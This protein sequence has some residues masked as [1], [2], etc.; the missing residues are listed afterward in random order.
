MKLILKNK[1]TLFLVSLFVLGVLARIFVF[2][3]NQ[4]L[5]V[6]ES[7]LA[8]NFLTLP[9]KGLLKGLE[10]MQASPAGYNLVNKFLLE[11]FK[12]NNVYFRDMELRLIPFISSILS[13]PAF[14]ILLKSL[15]KD[16][17]KILYGFS[18]LAVNPL[19]ILYAGQCKQYS[20][21]LLISIILFYCFYKISTEKEFRWYY[22]LI[23]PISVWF[24]YSAFFIIAAGMITLLVSKKFK[25]FLYLLAILLFSNV[26]YYFISLKS[27]FSVNYNGMDNFWSQSYA[28]MELIHP[29]RL[30]IRFGEL[31]IRL[32]S[33]SIFVGLISFYA[34]IKYSFNKSNPLAPKLLFCITI[35]GI[36]FA[37]ALHKYPIYARLI[38]FTLPIFIIAIT[39]LKGKT[40]VILKSATVLISG[41]ALTNYTIHAKEMAYSY[42]RDIVPYVIENVYQTD[43][44]IIDTRPEYDL[45]LL[46]TNLNN[47]I[48][49]NKIQCIEKNINK[50]E[51]FIETLP[52]GSYYYLSG[53][54]YVK[55]FIK[56]NK[57]E[58]KELNI[59]HKANKT[60]ALYFIKK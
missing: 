51:A 49:E 47:T 10:Y 52:K 25:E 31:F 46:G 16:R 5:W 41:F 14:L 32:K 27:V 8:I 60:K 34:L 57:Y 44:I 15:L 36:I 19:A 37:S 12:T 56:N 40:G 35:F 29:T 45:Y 23:I 9:Y 43:T 2:L 38:L 48:I 28:F 53:S 26:I 11:T 18:L 55:D 13:L 39:D 1:Q 54:Y 30:F 4:S 3:K 42:A 17:V 21:E 6:D 59:K 58:I 7:M 33:F 50:C 24:S 22:L 20:T